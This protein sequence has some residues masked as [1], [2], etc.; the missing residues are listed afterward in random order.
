MRADDRS[1]AG[2]TER[3][4]T[5]AA[6]TEYDYFSEDVR[7]LLRRMITDTISVAIAASDASPQRGVLDAVGRYRLITPTDEPK[8]SV[9]GT[10]EE[11][12]P[13]LAA[14]VVKI[15][16]YTDELDDVHET[17]LVH[18]PAPVL[19]AILSDA[20]SRGASGSEFLRVFAISVEVEARLGEA[21]NHAITS[22]AGTRL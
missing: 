4:A 9:I 13:A 16:A 12:D 1:D 17:M 7:R 15:N 18:L 10:R 5:S 14:L 2:A 11:T 22:G 20:E 21:I 3:L 6:D 8:A 19:A